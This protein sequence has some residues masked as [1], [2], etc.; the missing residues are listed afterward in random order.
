MRLETTKSFVLII[1]IGVSLL[2]TYGL[3]SYQPNYETLNDPQLL[4]EVDV[5]GT[6][7]IKKDMVTPSKMIFHSEDRHYGF[8]DPKEQQLFFKNMQ[9]WTMYNFETGPATGQKEKTYEVEVVFPSAI[10]MELLSTMFTLNDDDL[11]LPNWSFQR[12]YYTFDSSKA[13][14]KVRFLAEDGKKQATAVINDPNSYEQLW[15]KVFAP[16]GL[17]EYT[18]FQKDIYLPKDKVPLDKWSLT[19][20]RI[21]PQEF[22][23][24]LFANPSIVTRPGGS[25]TG[26]SDTYFTDTQRQMKIY[27]DQRME[28]ISPYTSEDDQMDPLTLLDNSVENINDHKGWT[29]DYYLLDMDTNGANNSIRYQMYTHGYPVYSATKLSLITQEW[30][31]QTLTKYERPLFTMSDPIN[32]DKVELPASD[33][34]ISYLENNDTFQVEDIQDVQLGYKLSYVDDDSYTPYVTLEPA[35]YMQIGGSWVEIKSDD[36]KQQ[37]GGD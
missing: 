15:S 18:L 4:N 8:Q 19:L 13:T 2:L 20:D 29:E 33:A 25:S 30:Y 28:F 26:E 37:K 22:V 23:N 24:A 3:W 14:L 7:E 32:S 31:D 9:S 21:E 1:L 36:L 11:K 5:G 10:P 35:W 34:V 6:T 17:S 16:K 12:M 27:R